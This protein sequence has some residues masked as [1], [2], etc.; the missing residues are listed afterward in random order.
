MNGYFRNS[1]FFQIENM[2]LNS[3]IDEILQIPEETLIENINFLPVYLVDFVKKKPLKISLIIDLYSH[4]K[5]CTIFN[6]EFEKNIIKTSFN[7]YPIFLR[8]LLELKLISETNIKNICVYE[9]EIS[10][11][12]FPELFSLDNFLNKQVSNY[13]KITYITDP[14]Y[15]NLFKDNFKLL[16]EKIQY[17]WFKD[18]LE[19]FLKYDEKENFINKFNEMKNP[20]N[21]NFDQFEFF[22]DIKEI[23]LINL[24][25]L[26]GSLKCFKFLLVSNHKIDVKNIEFA[27]INGNIELL[28][29]IEA[30]N[31]IE[32]NEI[33]LNICSKYKNFDLLKYLLEKK[34]EISN[35]SILK[36]FDFIGLNYFFKKDDINLIDE[37]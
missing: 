7:Q 37:K 29:E 23:S 25:C 34:V 30:L 10:K 4:L 26:Y 22:E 33:H 8:K 1:L 16:N 6:A 21:T 12:F 17:G 20:L 5:K 31:T 11:L 27:F 3:K 15:E 32:Y 35:I 14:Y 18:S 9:K 24:A 2:I 28:K 19:Y 36:N 13:R